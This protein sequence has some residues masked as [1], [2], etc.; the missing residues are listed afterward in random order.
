MEAMV[1]AFLVP[2][3]ALIAVF[4]ATGQSFIAIWHDGPVDGL[5]YWLN[6]AVSPEVLV[7][8]FFMMSDP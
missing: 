2:F 5:S 8:V 3:S 4:A 7:F 1:V 6:V